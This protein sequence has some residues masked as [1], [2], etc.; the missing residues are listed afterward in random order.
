MPKRTEAGLPVLR[1]RPIPKGRRFE[2][3]ALEEVRALLGATPRRR[4]LLIE[5]LHRIQDR[6]GHLSDRHLLALAHEMGLAAAEVYEVATFYHHFDVVKDGA[7][8]PPALTIRVCDSIACEMAGGAALLSTLRDRLGDR[9]RVIAAP[10]IGRCERA[11]AAFVGH[12]VVGPATAESVERAVLEERTTADVPEYRTLAG[13]RDAGGYGELAS[14][15]RGERSPEDVM[16]SLERSGLKGLGGAGFPAA[17]KWGF[18]RAEPGPRAV[19]VNADEGEP[20]TFK[21]RHLMETD[22]HRMLEGALI[23]AWAVEASTIYIYLRDEYPHC[24]AVMEDA[25]AALRADPP[26]PLPEIVLR[27]GAGAYICG[28]ET[29][30]IESLEGQR[31]EPRLRPPFPAQRG[32]FGRPTLV[33]NVETLYWVPAILAR[34]ADWFAGTGRDGH[35]G[36]R[37]YSVSGRVR[38]PGVYLAPNGVTVRELIDDYAG[39][40]LDG[41][42][43]YGY[44]PGGASGGIL[45]ASLGDIPL[46]FGGEL[47][48]YGCFVGSGAVVVLSDRDSARAAA[49]NVMRFFAHESCGKCTPC[50]VGTAKSVALMEVDDW[51]RAL[52]DELG[53]AMADASICGL[54]QAAPNVVRR[55]ME[56]FP[57]EFE[58]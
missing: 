35:P 4:D 14:C 8:P 11:P 47:G 36:Q 3:E 30:L 43:F 45:P 27:R 17:R 28:E 51:D 49:L 41:H 46:D 18:V 48:E 15:A 21:D 26:A 16:E 34:G 40:M 20:G 12:H 38:R 42:R 56:H 55:A 54:G 37:F 1:M 25:L 52:L 9:V 29:A 50:R 22:P 19:V 24:R 2:A 31:G 39:G 33:H 53:A 7:A 57:E 58:A 32:V 10:C 5:H 6:Y 44:L 23:A 13:Y